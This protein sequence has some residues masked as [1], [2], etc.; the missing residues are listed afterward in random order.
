MFACWRLHV[1]CAHECAHDLMCVH[2]CVRACSPVAVSGDVSSS[3]WLPVSPAAGVYG[4]AQ[5]SLFA[6]R[7]SGFLPESSDPYC[8]RP[9][10]LTLTASVQPCTRGKP[11]SFTCGRTAY[12]PTRFILPTSDFPLPLST[13]IWSLEAAGRTHLSP[14]QSLWH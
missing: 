13:P 3:V 7:A 6:C 2:M 4:R 1:A 11:A 9:T 14:H 8:Q 10:P 12:I 5:S